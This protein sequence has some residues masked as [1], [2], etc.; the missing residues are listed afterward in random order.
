MASTPEKGARYFAKVTEKIGG[1][2]ADL[3]ST[4]PSDLYE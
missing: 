1:F 2:L 4:D 3:S